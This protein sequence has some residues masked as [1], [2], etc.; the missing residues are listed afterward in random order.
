MTLTF[1]TNR[2]LVLELEF[3]WKPETRKGGERR[4]VLGGECSGY[5]NGSGAE[6][7]GQGSEDED[8]G[9]GRKVRVRWS[10]GNV[11]LVLALVFFI[12]LDEI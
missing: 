11:N 6:M 3:K 10:L 4:G 7:K 12:S 2:E 1:G 5:R 9:D 8:S